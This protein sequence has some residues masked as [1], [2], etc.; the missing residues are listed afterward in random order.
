M[1]CVIGI[2]GGA[3]TTRGLLADSSGQ[4]LASGQRTGTNYHHAGLQASVRV[5]VDLC[6]DLLHRGQRDISD[7]AAIC[8][9]LA[10]VGRPRD[11]ERVFALLSDS[12]SQERLLLVTDADIA[13]SGGCLSEAGV[14]V[15]AG[16][17]SIV[18]G[19]DASGHTA[20]VGG[21][22]HFLSDEG[23]GYALAREG[24]RAILR[25]RD[26]LRNRTQIRE[27]V[28]QSLNLEDEDDLVIWAMESVEDKALVAGLAGTILDCC[29]EGDPVATEIVQEAAD[30]L[31]LGA[32]CVA[33][34]LNLRDCFSVVLGGGLLDHHACYFDLLKR[35]I[36]GLLPAAEIT[37]PK[38][39]PVQ[40]SVLH[41]LVRAGVSISDDVLTNLRVTTPH[42]NPAQT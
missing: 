42:N 4:V 37:P 31:S 3:T 32:E 9:G 16:T 40:G 24:L 34:Q 7:F 14:L 33:K 13:L 35:K 6:Q 38:M 18:Y 8:F 21:Y 1:S 36:H 17:G 23:S 41:A 22:G 19:R 29:A 15:L 20:R 30:A 11:R 27:K 28:L 10:G 26:G 39:S 25:A 5:L 12:F 2:D